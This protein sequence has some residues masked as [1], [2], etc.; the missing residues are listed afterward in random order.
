MSQ[1]EFP[2]AVL[3][4]RPLDLARRVRGSLAQSAGD[5]PTAAV[6]ITILAIVALA[7]VF[8]DVLTPFEYKKTVSQ[9]LLPPL[10]QAATGGTHWL[11]TD[12]IGR[13]FFSRLLHGGR[14]SLAVGL[15]A[16][17]L[18]ISAG[19]L[20]AISAAYFG[21]KTDL[22][23]QR[24][25]DTLMVIPNLVLAMAITISLGFT[26]PVVIFALAVGIY[27]NASRLMRSHALVLRNAQYVEAARG[28]GCTSP[29]I[30]LKHLVPNSW[31]PWIVLL[32][33]NVGNAIVIESS[34]SFL[35]IG[36]APP[37]PSWGNLLTRANFFYTEHPHLVIAPGLIITIVV[38]CTNMIG[39]AIRD[40][41][42]PRLR[43]AG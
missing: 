9:R 4:P 2:G 1:P 11:G 13:D 16:P 8:A 30:I 6:A 40:R 23:V 17:T 42:D 34:L 27:P 10:S 18:G 25:T 37:T 33:V 32:G 26:T 41:L 38:L 39:D 19:A 20:I 21:G 28:V 7:V 24:L 5:Y 31:A 12:D 43:G 3:R 22:L 14:V 35:G 29:R 36:I 15:I